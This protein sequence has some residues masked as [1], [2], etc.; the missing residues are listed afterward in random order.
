M[1]LRGGTAG[2]HVLVTLDAVGGVWQYAL[3]LARGLTAHGDR[4]TLALLG[5]APSVAQRAEAAAIAGATLL[6]TG[7][8]LD[9]TCDAPAP[10][11]AAGATLA[12]LA[13]EAGADLVHLDSPA[14][15]AGDVFDM[16]VIAATHGCVATWWAVAH[17]GAT[18][19]PDLVW[20]HALSADGLAAADRVIAPTLAHAR[21]VRRAYA[22][23]A[24]PQVVHNGRTP[25]I[26]PARGE[27]APRA[28]TAGRLWDKVKRADLLDRVAALLPLP[29]DAAG[30]TTGPN[31][32]AVA[33]AHLNLLGMLDAPVLA[34]RLAERPVFVSAATFEPFGLAVL[35]AAQAGCALVLADTASARELWDNAA[36]FMPTDDPAG[37]A[38]AIESLVREPRL[39]ACLADAAQ[40]RSRR[41]TPAAMAAATRAI[42]DAALAAHDI[43]ERVAP[44]PKERIAA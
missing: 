7:Q 19:P 18:L 31:S 38:R 4:V 2:R 34:A 37:W 42:H 35:E 6:E 11:R 29:F 3:D 17:P 40:E 15:A 10:V 16:P 12:T 30:P 32:E 28:L 24:T 26:A 44:A 8:P 20:H 43:P 39:R 27:P 21:A 36:L 41:F 25:P 14:L 9:W 1:T 22:L 33:P 13:R 5:P 23:A